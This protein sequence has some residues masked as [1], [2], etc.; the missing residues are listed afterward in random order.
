[1]RQ[2][3]IYLALFHGNLRQISFLDLR[4]RCIIENFHTSFIDGKNYNAGVV[5]VFSSPTR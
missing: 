1:M 3:G 5:M 2:T 4:S